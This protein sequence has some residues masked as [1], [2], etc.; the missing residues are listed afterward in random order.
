VW[1]AIAS[2][3]CFSTLAQFQRRW[4]ELF[5]AVAARDAARMARHARELLDT[6]PELGTDA[7]E[8]LVL[9]ALAGSVAAADKP[10]AL[11][12]WRAQKTKLR[13]PAAPALRLLRCHAEA[14]SCAAEFRSYAE[15]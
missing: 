13:A 2:T 3:R 5:A 4:I 8:Y 1:R 12:L 7:R 15:R 14:A 9:A 11:E 10:A 6:T